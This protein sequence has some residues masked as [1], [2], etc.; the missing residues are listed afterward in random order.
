MAGEDLCKVVFPRIDTP[1]GNRYADGDGLEFPWEK[2]AGTD[3]APTVWTF[4]FFV[5]P[6]EGPRVETFR[7]D[8]KHREI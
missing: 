1:T 3:L 5:P 2:C 8:R 6:L 4:P 7:V